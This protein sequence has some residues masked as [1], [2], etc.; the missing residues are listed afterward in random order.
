MSGIRLTTQPPNGRPVRKDEI[1]LVERGLYIESWL[2]ER[3]SRRRPLFFVHGELAGSWLWERWLG[4]FAARGWETHALNL[5]NHFWSRTADP[6]SLSFASYVDDVVAALERLG[7]GVVA[8]GH[9]MGGLLVLKALERVSVAG[10]V[11]LAPELPAQVRVPALPH[12]L[13]EVP[14]VYGRDLIGWETLP[15]K[16][17]RDHRDLTIADVLR[18]QHLLGQ[19][20]RESGRA[21]REMMAGVA[22]DRR[23]IAAIPRLVIGAGLDLHVPEPD[24]ERLA[25]WLGAEY[26]P[27]GAHSHY[28]LVLGEASYLQVV[29]AVRAFLDAHR[30]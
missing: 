23:R 4:Y 18:I 28:G 19:K 15:E 27:F 22:V 11:L 5:R 8:V 9:G 13:R 12:E 1:E 21:R 7:S 24:V 10:V 25:S 16:L 14:D 20:P 26:E 2:P 17:V 3:R 30:L 6:A 29:E